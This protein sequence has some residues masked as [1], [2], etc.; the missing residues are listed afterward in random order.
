MKIEEV[1]TMLRKAADNLEGCAARG[2]DMT[3][4]IDL[5]QRGADGP[6]SHWVTAED[7][8]TAI[9]SIGDARFV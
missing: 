7:L 3:S 2:G 5:G 9:S 6:P 4:M 1:V 8:A